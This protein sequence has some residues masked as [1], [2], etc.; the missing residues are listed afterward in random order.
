MGAVMLRV[1]KKSSP[2]HEPLISNRPGLPAAYVS[3]V[4]SR[5]RS[6]EPSS[7][8]VEVDEGKCGDRLCTGRKK[9]GYVR[10]K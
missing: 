3:R 7:H 6:I 9:A 2:T 8:R 4:L 10:G 5:R 1:S